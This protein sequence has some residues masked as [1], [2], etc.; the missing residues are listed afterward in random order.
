MQEQILQIKQDVQNSGN[1][2]DELKTQRISTNE[3]LEKTEKDIEELYG[4][5]EGL[6]EQLL[7][8]EV[9]KNKINKDIEDIINKMWE[10]YE[11]TPNN[12][13]EYE[14]PK[15]TMQTQKKVNEIRNSIKNLGSINI[16]SIEEYKQISQRYDFMCEQRLDLENSISKLKKVI[17]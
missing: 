6:K 8:I 1:K 17:V 16:D 13:Q 12:A 7:K 9:K 4:I 15:N 11:L 2:V 3:E 10:E 14:K 5:I